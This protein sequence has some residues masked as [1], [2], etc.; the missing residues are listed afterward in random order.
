MQV[1]DHDY[2]S[3]DDFM[4]AASVNLEKF[5]DGQYVRVYMCVC[6][7]VCCVCIIVLWIFVCIWVLINYFLPLFVRVH[8]RDVGL[9]DP[10]CPHE[11][12]GYIRLLIKID[13]N[14][15]KLTTKTVSFT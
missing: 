10:S 3:A 12:L 5:A 2:G 13:C 15:S 14:D 9:S 1:F 8:M 7:C 11:N 4:G 6:V